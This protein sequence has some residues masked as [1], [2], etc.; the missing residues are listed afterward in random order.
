MKNKLP[1]LSD[2]N[3]DLKTAYKSDK[4]NLLLNVDPPKSWL[5]DHPVAKGV[6]YISIAR[7]ES[8]LT[9][10][11]QQWRAEVIEYKQMFNSVTCHVRLHYLNPVT[12]QWSFHD[13]LGAVS[14]Q[15]EKGKSAADLSS[16]KN[17]AVMKALPAAKSFA[18]KDAAEHLGKLF[19][20]DI[21]RKDEVGFAPKYSDETKLSNILKIEHIKKDNG[22]QS[23]R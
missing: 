2:L 12:G 19:G 16:I 13:G 20:R 8:N 22:H 10:I 5:K 18:I 3:S 1:T 6:K 4:L 17:D 21:N 15:T 14:V 9:Q 7:I 23:D 11:F